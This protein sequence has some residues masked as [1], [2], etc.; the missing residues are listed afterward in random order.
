M[1][2]AE[3]LAYDPAS[4]LWGE[5][6][7]RYRF[8][9]QFVAAGQRVLD[10]ASGA[11]FGLQMLRQADAQ[12]IGLDYDAASLAEVRRREP[13]AYLVNADATRLPLAPASIDL[14][15]SFETIEHVPDARATVHELRRV[16]K[17]EGRLV[18]STPNRGFGPPARHTDNPFHIQEFT[19]D[20]LRALL[21]EAFDKV[22]LYGQRPSAAYRYVPFLMIAPHR[23]P[24]AL[25]WKL[26]LRLPFALRNRVA[27]ALGG[28]PFYPGEADYCFDLETYAAAHAL[29]AVAC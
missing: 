6:R 7:S 10:V 15:V 23:E 14:V 12:P 3:R 17:P 26:L 24:A 25:V 9:T 8:A 28:R 4:E 1:T 5:H 11:G 20:E 19:A 13:A 22:K 27:L 2:A 21:R 29:V 16:L 18:L